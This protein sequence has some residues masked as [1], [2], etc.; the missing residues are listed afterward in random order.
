MSCRRL[1]RQTSGHYEHT[2]GLRK[3]RTNLVAEACGDCDLVAALGAAA[4]KYG[5]ACLGLHAREESVG[6]GAVAAV[7]L[8]GT[9]RHGVAPALGTKSEDALQKTRAKLEIVVRIRVSR[10]SP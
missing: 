8:E 5:S 4:A 10:G 1:A 9:L 6:L 3:R 2:P 7:W